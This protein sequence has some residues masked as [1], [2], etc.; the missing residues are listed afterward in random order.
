MF[1]RVCVCVCAF[2]CVC[3]T[4]LCL[5]EPRVTTEY[6]G[7]VI[8][9][10]YFIKNI[11]NIFQHKLWSK[12]NFCFDEILT[13]KILTLSSSTFSNADNFTNW[14]TILRSR[15]N[16]GIKIVFLLKAQDDF[17]NSRI[18]GFEEKPVKIILKNVVDSDCISNVPFSMSFFLA[19]D[20]HF[21]VYS[22]VY[23]K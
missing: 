13:K 15:K 4:Q 7:T 8:H 12:Q 20:S 1:T 19:S 23:P 16:F 18:L 17:E 21:F 14:K 22:A 9:P 6:F 2:L 11:W 5:C 10:S 3:A